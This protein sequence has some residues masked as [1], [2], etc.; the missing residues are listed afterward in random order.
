LALLD[1]VAEGR[2][3]ADL[4]FV[5]LLRILLRLRDEKLARMASLI[6][7]LERSQDALPLSSEALVTLVS[8]HLACKNAS[9]LPVLIIAA[10]YA[11]PF[12][13]NHLF[14]NGHRMSDLGLCAWR[15]LQMTRVD[16]LGC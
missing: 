6:A 3:Q 15:V 8:Q 1:D 11:G 2:V 10:A 7:A 13:S 9:R 5:E 14:A 16:S 4:L 12:S